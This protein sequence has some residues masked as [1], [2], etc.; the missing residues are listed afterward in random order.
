[1]AL[2]STHKNATPHMS[3]E[4]NG[5]KIVQANSQDSRRQICNY[6]LHFS[7]FIHIQGSW[8]LTVFSVRI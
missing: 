6:C 8:Y 4:A 2:Y 7:H 5:I 3:S 1:M